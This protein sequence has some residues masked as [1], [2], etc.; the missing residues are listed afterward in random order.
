[1]PVCVCVFIV[2]MSF[3]KKFKKKAARGTFNAIMAIDCVH[4]HS[5]GVYNVDKFHVD[6][7]L[8]HVSYSFANKQL[9]K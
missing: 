8:C 3:N 9:K 7:S 4:H 6:M 5:Q 1:M 2:L